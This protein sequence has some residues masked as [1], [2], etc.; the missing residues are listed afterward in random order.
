MYQGVEDT[1]IALSTPSGESLRS[2]LRISGSNAQVCLGEIFVHELPS[3]QQ[4]IDKAYVT[5]SNIVAE[6]DTFT[7]VNGYLIVEE[8][9]IPA[10]LYIMKAPFSFTK[11]D[12]VEIHTIGSPPLLEMILSTIL[13][14]SNESNHNLNACNNNLIRLA[15][16]GEFTKR[17][18]LNGRI[19][20]SQAEAVMKLIR[21][22]SDGEILSNIS[23]LKGES[24]RFVNKIKESLLDLCGKIEAS[25]DFSDQDISLISFEEIE[26]QLDLVYDQIVQLI[27]G[28]KSGNHLVSEGINIMLYGRPNVGKSSL[29]NCFDPAIKTIVSNIPHTTRDSLKRSIKIDNIY[30][31][32]YDNPGIEI[33]LKDSSTFNETDSILDQ[34]LSND[35]LH[36]ADTSLNLYSF[37]KTDEVLTCA[38]LVVLVLDGSCEFTE[39]DK[40]LLEKTAKYKNLIVINKSDLPQ[41]IKLNDVDTKNTEVTV[42]KT[43]T[44]TGAGIIEIKEELLKFA[45]KADIDRATSCLIVN[46]RQKQELNQTLESLQSALETTRNRDSFEFIALDLR[47][48]MDSLGEIAGEVVTDDI[49]NKIF[50][51]FCIGK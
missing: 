13:S 19:N 26:N 35:N 18:F 20:I 43:S 36:E 27:S 29:L 37:A 49:L 10:T 32:F 9:S 31:N 40:S 33:E 23:A 16:P 1:I 21:S 44:V 24:G 15:E 11:E 39:T 48:A 42:I 2:I 3:R 46:A 45:S 12:V 30:F 50:F 6:S 8:T 14:R 34:D 7:S 38:D 51:D 5:K 17:A 25:I 41:K 28:R 22:S 47:S 4:V